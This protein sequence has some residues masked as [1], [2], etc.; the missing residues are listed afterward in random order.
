MLNSKNNLTIEMTDKNKSIKKVPNKGESNV[1]H[2]RFPGFEGEWEVKKLGEVAPLQ[3]GFDLPNQNIVDGN[4]PI[5]YSNG[6]L[7]FHNQSKS[8]AP[9][10]ITGR[11]GTIGKFTF[12]EDGEYWPHN[13]SLWVTD[14]CG[15]I[16][17]YIY[18]LYQTIN[19][20]QFSTGS[21]VPTLNR[22]DVHRKKCSIPSTAEQ[23]KIAEFL[24]ALDSKIQT[25]KKTIDVLTVLK[26]SLSSKIFSREIRFK[27]EKGNDFPGWE[28]K[29]LGDISNITMGQSPDS[30]SY[31]NDG[32]GIPLIQGNADIVNRKSNPRQY[33]NAPT[34]IC[35]VGDI[36]LTVRAPVG[37]VAKSYHNACIGRGMCLLNNN[38]FS[39]SEF[40][41]QFLLHFENKWKS[42]EQGST[43]TSVNSSDINSIRLNVPSLPEQQKIANFLFS[44]D[45]KIDVENQILQQL[46]MQKKY[47][48]A[49]LFI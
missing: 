25:Q 5:V 1:P 22:N 35:K 26:T 24:S 45:A 6:I 19:I 15:N 44:I 33:T 20:E 27:D 38:K 11:S 14:F 30:S 37:Y 40:I 43:F 8:K 21:G 9:G 7:K 46:E 34:K 42:I 41:Y 12:I 39:L 32:I 10:L 3:R 23:K 48:L 4:I 31:N 29:K 18:Y 17:K 36:L 16:P 28:S 47:F 49:N 13:T 2:L